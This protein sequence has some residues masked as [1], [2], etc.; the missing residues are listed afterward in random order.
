MTECKHGQLERQ[1]YTCELERRIEVLEIALRQ[2]IDY[3][4]VAYYYE[5]EHRK[6]R[7]DEI[8]DNAIQTAEKNRKW[9]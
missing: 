1:C 9:W 2:T 5:G 6:K 8:M 7:V 4:A 3:C